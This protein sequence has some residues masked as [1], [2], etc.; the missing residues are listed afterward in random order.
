MLSSSPAVPL[1]SIDFHD[2]DKRRLALRTH[3][4]QEYLTAH[5]GL[6]SPEHLTPISGTPRAMTPES[7]S[8]RNSDL[9]EEMDKERKKERERLRAGT[10]GLDEHDGF[11]TMSH[12]NRA[13]SRRT[14]A[15]NKED[16]V[17]LLYHLFAGFFPIS[18]YLTGFYRTT[19]PS[20]GCLL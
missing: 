12:L 17:S 2:D 13:P 16:N 4:G 5:D 8:R 7:L 18:T 15:A 10:L 3:S 11:G 6:P 1:H 19:S 9:G 14:A 20:F